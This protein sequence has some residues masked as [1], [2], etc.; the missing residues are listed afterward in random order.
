M[1]GAIITSS[2]SDDFQEI[3][4][5]TEKSVEDKTGDGEQ[6]PGKSTGG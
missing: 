6:D 5:A 3:H 2:C 4:D 1:V